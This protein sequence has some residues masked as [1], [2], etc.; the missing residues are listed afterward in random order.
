MVD[1]NPCSDSPEETPNPNPDGNAPSDND[2]APDTLAKKVQESLMLGKR[3][4]FWET[5]PV[6]QF[7]DI[8]DTSLPEGPIEPPTPLSEVKQESYN[9]PNPY[10]WITCDIDSEEMCAE[11]YNLLTHNYVEDD[12]NMFRFNYSKEFLH[13]ALHPPGYY[14]S[15]HIGVRARSSKKLVA[16]ITG[17]PARIRVRDNV[18]TMAEINFLCVHKKLRSKRLAPVMIKEVTR[19]VHLENIWQAAY[20]AGVVLPTPMSTCQYWHRSLNP[21]KLIDVGFSRLGARMTMSRTIKLYKLPD[22]TSTPGFRKMELHDVPAVT[23]LLRNY[24]NQFDVAPDFDENDV[25]HWLLP[26]ENVVDSYV[27]ES[28]E[29]HKVTDFCSFYSLPSSILGNQNYSILK[30]AYSFYNVA[31]KTPFLQLMNDVLIV[32]KQKDYDVFNALDVMQNETFIKDLKFGPGDGKLHY[33]LYNYRLRSA[34]KPMELGL[35]LL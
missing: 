6:G 31:T 27:V 16:F 2:L 26:T 25:E 3:H 35:V 30:A 7:K 17:V 1:S 28:P 32:A 11:V 22:S 23:Q 20:T 18:V 4:K 15:W 19:R 21:K 29:S 5:Q 12:E 9:L 14:K 10:E 33:Y 24:L 13:W 34:L 8:G